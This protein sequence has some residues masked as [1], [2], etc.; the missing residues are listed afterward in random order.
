MVCRSSATQHTAPWPATCFNRIAPP[1]FRLL[2][3]PEQPGQGFGRCSLRE[4]VSLENHV[5]RAV[6]HEGEDMYATTRLATCLTHCGVER[7][8]YACDQESAS[9]V[10][11]QFAL[12]ICGKQ[13][14]WAGALTE[15]SAVGG[16]ASNSRAERTVF[17]V[18]D[19]LRTYT[20]AL[21]SKIWGQDSRPSPG[22]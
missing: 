7:C 8:V 10:M 16:S 13:G 17:A 19:Q 22:C 20:A 12:R 9:E 6:R 15:N 3:P 5:C 14:R 2:F 18:E 21:E 1:L 4:T 11:I